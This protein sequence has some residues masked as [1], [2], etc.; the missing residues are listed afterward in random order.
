MLGINS[1]I[2]FIPGILQQVG[3]SLKNKDDNNTGFDDAGGNVIIALGPVVPA[4]LTGNQTLIKKVLWGVYN[5]IGG[6]LGTPFVEPPAALAPSGPLAGV[7]N[8]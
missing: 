2:L 4:F 5:T 7:I 8:S 6:Y 1:L 3:M